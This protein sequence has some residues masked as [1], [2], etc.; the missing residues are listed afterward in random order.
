MR[1]ASAHVLN[2]Y[3]GFA[4]RKPLQGSPALG[5]ILCSKSIP[6]SYVPASVAPY[7]GSGALTTTAPHNL[8]TPPRILS[9]ESREDTEQAKAWIDKFKT[10]TLPRGV[11]E[12]S[13]SRSSGPG[14]QNVN[15]VNTKATVRCALDAPWIPTWAQRSLRNSPHYVRSSNSILIT[16]TVH[17]SQA[18]NINECLSKLHGLILTTSTAPIRNEPSEEQKRRVGALEQAEKA[19]RRQ[20]KARRSMI[21]KGRARGN[22]GN[23]D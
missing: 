11:V 5:S 4:L 21:K 3:H 19:R 7:T 12:L 15:K 9:L 1:F 13:F 6:R 22:H 17:R 16:S 10:A 2:L 14:G 18:Q 20:D 23:W 8:P